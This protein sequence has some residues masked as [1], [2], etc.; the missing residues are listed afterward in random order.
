M[1]AYGN[2][3]G[4]I[5]ILGAGAWGTALA[6]V[7]RRA[8]RP[9]RLWGRDEAVLAAIAEGRGNPVYL[10]GIPLEPGIET[11]ADIKAALDGSAAVLLVCPAQAV[12]AVTARAA[13]YISDDLPVALCA[14]GVERDSALLMSEVLAETVPGAAPAVLSGPTFAAE[15]AKGLPT[16]VTLAARDPA[17]GRFLQGA[18]AGERFRPYLSDD[19]IGVEVAGAAKNVIAI[20]CGIAW[21]LG[22]GENACAALLTRGLAEIGRLAGALGGRAETMAGLSGL[23]D[24]TLTA[25]SKTSRNTRFGI[26]L[27]EGGTP[28][29]PGSR[30]ALTEGVATAAAIVALAE[31]AGVSDIPIICAVDD[32]LAGRLSTEEAIRRLLARPVGNEGAG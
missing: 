13:P 30:P 1:T 25:G 12:R 18:L 26:V 16:A 27:G 22:L 21:G 2:V 5:T 8:G 17:M 10:P 29:D 6:C 11:T 4:P 32:V 14:K 23:G 15:V 3:S 31:R 24:L 9:V 19:V 28:A 7:A 20:A